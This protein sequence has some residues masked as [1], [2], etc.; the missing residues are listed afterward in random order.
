MKRDRQ[1]NVGLT[2]PEYDLLLAR[3]A[4]R[5]MRPV[6]YGRARLLGGNRLAE[7]APIRA[8]H[9]DPLFIAQLSR[10]GNNLNQL[11]RQLNTQ[12]QPAPPELRPLLEKIR[13]LIAQGTPE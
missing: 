3:A 12:P 9:L 13:Q 4:A 6:D 8:P 2:A 10:I 7:T 5:G 1:F 11:A